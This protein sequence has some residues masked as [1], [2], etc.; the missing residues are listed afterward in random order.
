MRI[1][2]PDLP[3]DTFLCVLHLYTPSSSYS[4]SPVLAYLN[5][6]ARK[7]VKSNICRLPPSLSWGAFTRLEAATLIN[8]TQHNACHIKWHRK[9]QSAV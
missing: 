2:N 3:Y 9:R 5:P 6:G 8:F 4:L 7:T 1:E